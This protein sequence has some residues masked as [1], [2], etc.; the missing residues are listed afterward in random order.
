MGR[1]FDIEHSKQKQ[2][3]GNHYSDVIMSMM[4]SQIIHPEMANSAEVVVGL[5]IVLGCVQCS[6]SQAFPLVLI[7]GFL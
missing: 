2:I 4:A 3:Q 7:F 5:I 6:W 1:E